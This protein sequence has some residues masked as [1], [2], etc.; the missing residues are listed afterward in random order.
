MTIR[1]VTWNV[2]GIRNPFKYAPWNSE[3]TL[4]SM[5]N[6]LEGDIV[7]FQEVKT[8]KAGL[9][10]DLVVVDGWDTFYSF[11]H[12]QTAVYTRDSKCIP[13]RVEEGVTGILKIPGT[14]T[15]YIDAAFEKQIGGYPTDRQL[16]RAAV[17]RDVID[18]EGRCLI[19]EFPLFVLINVYCP[20]RRNQERTGYRNTFL[21]ALDARIRNLAAMGKNIVLLGDLNITR[22]QFDTAG[23]WDHQ[24]KKSM[25]EA[26]E[27]D[28][29][30]MTMRAPKL[31]NQ[32]LFNSRLI[33]DLGRP[34]IEDEDKRRPPV[35]Y[36]TGRE[37]HPTRTGMFT[38]WDTRKNHR[39]AN[40][41]SRIDYIAC[42]PKV[43]QL[44]QEAEIQP[45]LHGSDHCPV[46][47]VLRESLGSLEGPDATEQ[48]THIL[49]YL[50]PPGRFVN[51]QNVLPLEKD[52]ALIRRFAQ[53]GRRL[54]Q[55]SNR[56]HIGNM[57]RQVAKPLPAQQATAAPTPSQV[58]LGADIPAELPS[59]LKAEVIELV[60]SDDDGNMSNIEDDDS[61]VPN[62][63]DD[64]EDDDNALDSIPNF[65]ETRKSSILPL[66][67]GKI[68]SAWPSQAVKT[69]SST[70]A[71]SVDCVSETQAMERP[72]TPS[73]TLDEHKLAS[74]P[75][76]MKAAGGDTEPTLAWPRTPPNSKAAAPTKRNLVRARSG[77]SSSGSISATALS[78]S[79]R[80]TK[81]SRTTGIQTSMS[82]FLKARDPLP[83]EP[84]Q[85]QQ[86]EEGRAQ[87]Q[88]SE[89]AQPE[90]KGSSSESVLKSEA[91]PSKRPSNSPN[92][93]QETEPDRGPP[94]EED[95]WMTAEEVDAAFKNL[96]A[97]KA[98]WSKLGLGQRQAP[99]CEHGEPCKTLVT[100]KAG[101][102]SGRSFFMCSRP[103]G[104]LGKSEKGTAWQCPTF[105]W[106]RDWKPER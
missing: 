90:P 18:C 51:G 71:T 78:S 72:A 103:P 92:K 64:D 5:F 29:G 42:S 60:E 53:S 89:N 94:K 34:F 30:Y 22:D 32:L 59:V 77:T 33:S 54:P 57:F 13:L 31:L 99:L 88:G 6:I 25:S 84:Q 104:P 27:F 10:D 98:S 95:L 63:I 62:M 101:V 67:A 8:P 61:D 80:P 68:S 52:A 14:H 48:T 83:V 43:M 86:G 56:R 76:G 41:G 17:G 91:L 35:L 49:D 36:D 19:L 65:K 82:M 11:P 102:N 46:Y 74:Q 45:Q 12:S 96:D 4:Q 26:L 9:T 55:F 75:T 79:S 40:Y 21:L 81:K 97:A 105:V 24:G 44:V 100:K 3:R 2:N 66:H 15:R 47:I 16:R 20:A 69:G 106:C 7:C 93:G 37:L 58:D 38:C 39:P 28:A 70:S 73:S 50:N 85:P 87:D 23:I 1:I